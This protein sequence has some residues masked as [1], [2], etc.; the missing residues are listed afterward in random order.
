MESATTVGGRPA[1]QLRF[2]PAIA[3]SP[4]RRIVTAVDDQTCAIL[5]ADFQ[6]ADK[7]LKHYE[8]DPAS[9]LRSGRYA[10]ASR[11]TI[12]DR[13]RGTRA[14]V[15][16]GGVSTSAQVSSALLDPKSFHKRP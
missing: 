15:S 7:S 9:L 3:D 10:Y 8:I 2:V 4:Y 12:E 13:V 6:G 11:A 14:Q 16:L 5:R 1:K